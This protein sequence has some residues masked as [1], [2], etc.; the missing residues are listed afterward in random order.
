[1]L[2]MIL[3]ILLIYIICQILYKNNVSKSVVETFEDEPVVVKNPVYVEGIPVSDDQLSDNEEFLQKHASLLEKPTTNEHLQ[4]DE[5]FLR[6]Q[7]LLME[8]SATTEQVQFDEKILRE[9]G[10]I[11]TTSTTTEQVQDADKIVQPTNPVNDNVITDKQLINNKLDKILNINKNILHTNV[12]LKKKNI[13]NMEVL[14]RYYKS[15]V[16]ELKTHNIITDNDIKLIEKKRELKLLDISDI[17][18]NFEKL[19]EDIPKYNIDPNIDI[20]QYKPLG[21]GISNKWDYGYFYLNTDKWKVPM[22][23]PPPCIQTKTPADVY[24]YINPNYINLKEWDSSGK[25]FNK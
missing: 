3:Y 16:R 13:D 18:S 10:L 20:E 22:P 6:E 9:Q 4:D 23:R 5:A 25:I 17:I 15:L 21:D 11:L 2:R 7:G 24:P 1:M 12:K 8:T 19:Q 14:D